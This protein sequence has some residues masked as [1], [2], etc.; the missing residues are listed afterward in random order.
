MVVP[1]T[2]DRIN[3]ACDTGP[4]ISALQ[5]SAVELLKRYLA[6]LYITR[7]EQVE[8]ERHGWGHEIDALI[9]DGFV[10]IASDLDLA[11]REQA[12][13]LAHRIAVHPLSGSSDPAQHLPEAEMLVVSL[14]PQLRCRIVLLDEK[15]AR[16]IAL[17]IGLRV[18]G[19]PG[20]LARAGLDGLLTKSD[21]RKLLAS[22]QRQGTHYSDALITYVAETYG[23]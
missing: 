13:N 17:E 9:E 5:C 1:E 21:I 19:F 15:A 12:Q 20:I 16:A 6:R 18:T 10:T 2:Q 14:R 22:C 4:L 23:R 3:A 7:L 11:E 8:L